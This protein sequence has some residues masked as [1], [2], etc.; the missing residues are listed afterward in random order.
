MKQIT[1]TIGGELRTLDFGKMGF[2]KFFGQ[3][4][5]TDPIIDFSEIASNP[6]KQFDF[7]VG[8]VYGGIN[9]HQSFKRADLISLEDAT[10]WVSCME[11]SEAV[12]LIKKFTDTMIPAEKGEGQAQ[13]ES[14]SVG[15]N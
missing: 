8:L 15:M 11:E 5:K 9:C 13:P 14:P 2:S 10:Y 7:I 1:H 6:Q 3:A 12:D 4:T